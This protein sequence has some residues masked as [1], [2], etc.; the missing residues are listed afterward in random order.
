MARGQEPGK[1]RNRKKKTKI[2]VDRILII[3]AGLVVVIVLF[4]FVATALFGGS[5][6]PQPGTDTT[7]NVTGNNVDDE[8]TENSM[9]Q[10]IPNTAV[11]ITIEPGASSESSSNTNE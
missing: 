5:S 11:P 8:T 2:R 7:T 3:A 6:E 9:V 10:T 1:R 4:Y